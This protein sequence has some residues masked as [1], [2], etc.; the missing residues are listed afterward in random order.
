[1]ATYQSTHTGAQID[2]AVDAVSGKADKATTLSGYGVLDDANGRYYALNGG[3]ALTATSS[4]HYDLNSLTKAGSY[5][6]SSNTTAAYFDNMPS[7]TE[8]AFRIWVSLPTGSG[9]HRRQRFQ[10]YSLPTIYERYYNGS[11]W[12]GWQIVQA[13]LADYA[14]ASDVT[15]LQGY[16]TSGSA[17]TAVA[18][19]TPRTI[20]GQ[21]FDGSGNVSGSMTGV[22][23][24]TANG[25][26]VSTRTTATNTFVTVANS[27]GSIG[28]RASNPN[29]GLI[30]VTNTAWIVGTNGT[31]TWLSQGNIGI[32]TT[33]PSEKLH[34]VGNAIITG[35]LTLGGN[36]V[37]VVYSGSSAPS[38]ST[39]S[40]GDIYIQ[41][42]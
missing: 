15:T 28:I 42:S 13:N 23:S 8:N 32:G 2:T 14:S 29:R 35:T 30:D 27:I 7:S 22:G 17:N 34:V 24:I 5:Y 10:Y 37:S 11:D 40:D 41:T 25:D 20:W 12:G 19:N 38:S 3:T 18:L 9:S 1:M 36:P 39:G 26:Y 33:Q 4:S 21:S 6:C 16:F 31:N